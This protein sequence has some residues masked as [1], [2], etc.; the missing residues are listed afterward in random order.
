MSLA[1]LTQIIKEAS[2]LY[3]IPKSQFQS[4]FAVMEL[5]VQECVYAH[6]AWVFVGHFLNRLGT[7]LLASLT[8]RK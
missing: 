8:Y 4:H 6:C 3:C 7:H 1:M 5:S 2:L